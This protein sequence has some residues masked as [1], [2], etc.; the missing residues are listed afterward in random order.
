MQGP[1]AVLRGVGAAARAVSAQV[2]GGNE[3]RRWGGGQKQG[4]SAVAF[5]VPVCS[6]E[7][8]GRQKSQQVGPS[9]QEMLSMAAASSV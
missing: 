3:G 4:T 9:L 6:A 5:V 7:L 8:V 2:K 1:R